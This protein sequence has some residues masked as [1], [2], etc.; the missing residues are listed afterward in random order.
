MTVLFARR[1]MLAALT[2]GVAV[3]ILPACSSFPAFSLTEAVRRLLERSSQNAFARLLAPG[4]FYENGAG[5]IALPDTLGGSKLGALASAILMSATVRK[6]LTRAVN[7]AA[8]E[9]AE[10]AAPLVADAIRTLEP[11]DIEAIRR[12]G[13]TAATDVL[14]GRMGRSLV[15]AMVPEISGV[16]RVAEDQA[17]ASALRDLVGVDLLTLARD[18][19][20][21]AD[22]V[23]W[24]AIGSEEAAIR[25]DPETADDPMLAQLLGLKRR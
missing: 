24:T 8:S 3:S 20:T 13:P 12:G 11:Q 9:G 22:D 25:A 21:K 16:L 6:G 23:I 14:R 5:R 10:R 4:G 19:G 7:D 17:V 1:G 18:I 15:D 2:A